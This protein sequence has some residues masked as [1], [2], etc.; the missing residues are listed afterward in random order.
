MQKTG[1]VLSSSLF[2]LFLPN[3]L[4]PFILIFILDFKSGKDAISFS[5]SVQIEIA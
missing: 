3:A 1:M 4:D 2:L 5:V